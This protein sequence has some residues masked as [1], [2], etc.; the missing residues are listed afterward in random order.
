M[1]QGTIKALVWVGIENGYKRK[2]VK[3]AVG[4]IGVFHVFTVR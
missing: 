4:S 3:V 2:I 1:M